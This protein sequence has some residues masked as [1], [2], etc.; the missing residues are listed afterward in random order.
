MYVWISFEKESCKTHVFCMNEQAIISQ[1]KKQKIRRD[2]F[3]DLLRSE[4]FHYWNINNI[5]ESWIIIIMQLSCHFAKRNIIKI[6]K[7]ENSCVQVYV[8]IMYK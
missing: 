7:Y 2:F 5:N 4:V 8:I 6:V 3:Y 1:T